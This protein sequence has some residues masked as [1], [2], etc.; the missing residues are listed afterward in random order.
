[1]AKDAL[2]DLRKLKPEELEQLAMRC[3]QSAFDLIKEGKT[4]EG[5]KAQKEGDQALKRAKQL[6]KEMKAGKK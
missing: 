4:V 5:K 2:E 1:M 6:F 3:F